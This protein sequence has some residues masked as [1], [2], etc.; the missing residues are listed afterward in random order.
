[1]TAFWQS[2]WTGQNNCANETNANNLAMK[3]FW[4]RLWQIPAKSYYSS[5]VTKWCAFLILATVVTIIWEIF[6]NYFANN[7]H[8]PKR[9]PN[10]LAAEEGHRS[11]TKIIICVCF[12]NGVLAFFD[13]YEKRMHSTT[14]ASTKSVQQNLWRNNSNNWIT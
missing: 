7:S 11:N 1:M 13:N 8:P 12:R 2:S 4:L 5:T 9:S 3:Y 10:I 14:C 6:L